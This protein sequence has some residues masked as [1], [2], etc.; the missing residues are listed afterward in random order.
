MESSFYNYY[1]VKTDCISNTWHTHEIENFLNTQH[2]QLKFERK[3]RGSFIS[4]DPFISLQIL[5]V[6]DYDSWSSNNYNNRYT[7]YI[8]IITA[9]NFDNVIRQFFKD[10]SAFLGWKV[11]KDID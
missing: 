2:S 11:I 10:L 9:P 3:D 4:K 5:L 7:N 1:Y 8:A 6:K